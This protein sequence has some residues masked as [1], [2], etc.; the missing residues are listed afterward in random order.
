MAT[1]NLRDIPGELKRAVDVA[2]AKLGMT[3]KEFCTMV[4]RKAAG[5]Q[6]NPIS[7]S[8]TSVVV[9]APSRVTAAHV[10]G[11][12]SPEDYLAASVPE[13]DQNQI[14]PRCGK[15]EMRLRY[16]NLWRCPVCAYEE[17]RG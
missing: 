11:V 3:Q 5:I 8:V 2:A 9:T 6:E 7:S 4:L 10:A 16:E 15:G 12:A 14:C 1:I 17:Y 13:P